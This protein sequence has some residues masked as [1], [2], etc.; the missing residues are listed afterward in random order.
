MVEPYSLVI[1]LTL[2]QLKGQ[3]VIGNLLLYVCKKIQPLQKGDAITITQLE[4]VILHFHIL[5]IILCHNQ[6]D[7]IYS[8]MIWQVTFSLR[9]ET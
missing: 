5:S 7:I 6:G 4:C 9:R 1:S 8:L 2:L 3:S